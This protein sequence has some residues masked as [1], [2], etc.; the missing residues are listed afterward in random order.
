[1]LTSTLNNTLDEINNYSEE[2]CEIRLESIEEKLAELRYYYKIDSTNRRDI[3]N[4]YLDLQEEK[5][6]INK[7]LQK[8]N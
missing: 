8:F 5:R 1:M 4:E 7:Q 2:E 3:N 6:R